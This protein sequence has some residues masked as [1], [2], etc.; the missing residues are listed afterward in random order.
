M[1]AYT[2]ILT[3]LV[4]IFVALLLTRTDLAATVTRFRGM[5]YQ[6]REGGMVSNLYEVTFI[7]KTFQEQAIALQ[8]EDPTLRLEVVGDQ[9]WVLGEQSKFEGRFFLVREQEAISRN[10]ED[11]V[12]LLLQNG[13][14]IDR[15]KTSFVGPVKRTEP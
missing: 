11:V 4:G 2:A 13:E 1:K 7:N 8:P 3:L 6:E 12:L 14:V 9:R 5:T 10:Q 15:L